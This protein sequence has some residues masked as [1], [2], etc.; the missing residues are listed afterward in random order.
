MYKCERNIKNNSTKRIRKD[1]KAVCTPNPTRWRLGGRLQVGAT[2]Q[3]LQFDRRHPSHFYHLRSQ[4]A[5]L[6]VVTVVQVS[7]VHACEYY[8]CDTSGSN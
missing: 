8:K 2:S 1:T 4:E 5:C 6:K 7:Q 3:L